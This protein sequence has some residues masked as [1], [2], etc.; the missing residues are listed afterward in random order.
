MEG[1][2]HVLHKKDFNGGSLQ[3]NRQKREL[4]DRMKSFSSV[5]AAAEFALS[6]LSE[7]PILVKES[8]TYEDAGRIKNPSRPYVIAAYFGNKYYHYSYDGSNDSVPT[9]EIERTGLDQLESRLESIAEEGPDKIYWG[10][11]LKLFS[12]K[13]GSE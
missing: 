4:Y 13:G 1:K 2:Y 8:V 3:A 9:H 7:K 11:E 12:V 10:I 5:D 6:V